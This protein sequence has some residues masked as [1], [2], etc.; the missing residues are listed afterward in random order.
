MKS[1]LAIF[2]IDGSGKS[3]LA[4]ELIRQST[5]RRG[6]A[7]QILT[8]P[9]YHHTPGAPFSDLS[10]VFEEMNRLGDQLMNLE[11]KAAAVYLQLTLY[12][13]VQAGL[14]AKSGAEILVSERHP[15]VDSLVYGPFFAQRIE[16]NL[17]SEWLESRG[18]PELESFRAG[19]RSQVENWLRGENERLGRVLT[20]AELPLMLKSL[21]AR[22][23]GALLNALSHHYGTRLPDVAIFLDIEIDLA[24]ER[25]ASRAGAAELH[26][27]RKSLES[28]RNGY[29]RALDWLAQAHP[30]VRVVRLE[31]RAEKTV[32]E[33]A[34]EV[35]RTIEKE[36]A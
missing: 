11:W 33:L 5:S 2:G 32:T 13:R 16:K 24:L 21:Y 36:H 27:N 14:L 28:L 30:E 10:E 26:E 20:F 8:C 4:Q 15:L 29:A 34:Q 22:D 23:P 19:A 9:R 35:L 31:A 3:A 18:W 7:F 1:F 17:D 25:I 6:P 12:G